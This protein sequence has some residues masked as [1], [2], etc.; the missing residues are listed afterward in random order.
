MIIL[1]DTTG[2]IELHDAFDKATHWSEFVRKAN[3]QQQTIRLFGKTM[4]QPRLTD[5]YGETGVSYRYSNQ[6][7]VAKEWEGWLKELSIQVSNHCGVPFNSALLNYYRNGSDSMGLHAD[8]EPE[9]GRNPSI[10]SVSYGAKRKMVFR[11]NGTKEKIEIELKNGSLL[12][13]GGT[14]QHYWKHELPKSK[15]VDDARLNI[16]FRSIRPQIESR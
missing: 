15:K 3:L 16:T 11:K 5:F 2:R 6:T 13:M 7:M 14:L 1:D 8:N 4:L 10:A 9:L 12:L